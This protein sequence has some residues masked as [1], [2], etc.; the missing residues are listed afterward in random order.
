MSG[1]WIGPLVVFLAAWLVTAMAAVLLLQWVAP[2]A[3]AVPPMLSALLVAVIG[4][5]FYTAL[6][7]KLCS[8]RARQPDS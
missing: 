6:F 2:T 4:W 8:V 7:L 1:E 3:D 5:G